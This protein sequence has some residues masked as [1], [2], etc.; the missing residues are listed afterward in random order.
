MRKTLL[1]YRY[2]L[3]NLPLFWGE[4][5][6]FLN[7]SDFALRVGKSYFANFAF[8]ATRPFLQLACLEFMTEVENFHNYSMIC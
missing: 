2:R 4:L 3:M 7:D 5:S 6:N 8:N 1:I